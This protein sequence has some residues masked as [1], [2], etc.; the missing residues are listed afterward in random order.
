[1]TDLVLYTVNDGVAEITLNRPDKKNAI[2]LNMYEQAVSYLEQAA[3]D[4][5]V[6]VILFRGKGQSFCAGNDIQDFVSGMGSRENLKGV[7]SFLHQIATYKKPLLAAV[8]G[9]AVG[10]GTT[11]MMHCDL[12]VAAEDLKCQMPFVHLGLVPEAGATLIIPSMLGQRQAFELLVEGRPFGAEKAQQS[13][14]VNEIAKVETY[15]D[16][17]RERAQALARL[18]KE[19]V[20]ESKRLMKKQYQENLLAVID[21]ELEVFYE[22]LFSEEA[23]QAFMAFLQKG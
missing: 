1:M 22:R 7:V 3:S 23:R 16:A 8:Q 21:E 15:M 13:G 19:A 6:R 14:L 20:L 2:T 12:V 4:E 9:N 5:H 10:I 18:P 17:A 11:M